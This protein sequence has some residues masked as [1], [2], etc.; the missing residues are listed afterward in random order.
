MTQ[1]SGIAEWYTRNRYREGLHL[2]SKEFVEEVLRQFHTK[3]E[4]Q[5]H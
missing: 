1:P 4:K 3:L 2:D 5:T